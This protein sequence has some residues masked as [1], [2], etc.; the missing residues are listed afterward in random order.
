MSHMPGEK[1][2][3]TLKILKGIGIV[4][5][6]AVLAMAGFSAFF[7]I[8]GRDIDPPDVSD[9]MPS[10]LPPLEQSENIVSLNIKYLAAAGALEFLRIPRI[11]QSSEWVGRAH[12]ARRNWVAVD[13]RQ[14]RLFGALGDRALPF[15]VTS[16]GC[17]TIRLFELM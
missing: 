12:R 3:I 17:C 6:A 14:A 7:F 9:L 2:T 4:V 1:H 13:T 15:C 8:A 5:A 16:R 11:L 10:P